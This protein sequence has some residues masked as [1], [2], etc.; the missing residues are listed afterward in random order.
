MLRIIGIGFHVENYEP[1]IIVYKFEAIGYETLYTLT[2]PKYSKVG[3]AAKLMYKE[4]EKQDPK[5]L[6]FK[7]ITSDSELL[8]HSAIIFQVTQGIIKTLL[9]SSSIEAKTNEI[10]FRDYDTDMIKIYIKYLYF[11]SDDLSSVLTFNNIFEEIKMIDSVL[12]FANFLDDI[13]FFNTIVKYIM[14]LPVKRHVNILFQYRDIQ[15]HNAIFQEYLSIL[16]IKSERDSFP[17]KCKK[18]QELYTTKLEFIGLFFGLSRRKRL[19]VFRTQEYGII[20]IVLESLNK[21]RRKLYSIIEEIGNLSGD[22][23]IKIDHKKEKRSGALVVPN[24][25]EFLKN[26]HFSTFNTLEVKY[27]I[28]YRP[29]YKII[30]GNSHEKILEKYYRPDG[31]NLTSFHNFEL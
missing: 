22:F 12:N 4:F 15:S 26:L 25:K 20:S 13:D 16:K 1:G 8:L 2:R 31:N 23:L 5:I 10:T 17:E 3:Y 19:I 30:Q 21:S 7:I 29:Q 28:S 18:I 24:L 14:E 27:D 6:D 9:D 11:S